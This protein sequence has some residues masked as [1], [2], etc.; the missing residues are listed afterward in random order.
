MEPL[1]VYE[2]NA[3]FKEGKGYTI[4]NVQGVKIALVA[5]TKGMDGL[6]LPAGNEKCV[7]VLYKDYEGSA[8]RAPTTPFRERSNRRSPG[9]LGSPSR[10]AAAD[11]PMRGFM[12]WDRWRTSTVK[13]KCRRKKS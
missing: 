8:K 5:F 1:G 7:N 2:S 3:A 4:R 6:A 10:S 9:F 11:G 13:A 12:P